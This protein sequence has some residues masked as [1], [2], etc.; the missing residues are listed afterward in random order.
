MIHYLLKSVKNEKSHVPFKFGDGRVINS[1]QTITFPAKIG[2]RFCN[3]KT[4]VVECKIPLLLSK[5]SLAKT[6]AVIDIGKD[7]VMIFSQKVNIKTTS[8]GHYCVNIMRKNKENVIL[9]VDSNIKIK[10]KRN[11]LLK[12]RKQ[13]GHASQEKL[14]N[15][16]KRASMVN[17]ET[18]YLLKDIYK[19]C[20]IC[21]KYTRPK[22]KPIVGFNLTNNFNQVIVLDLHEL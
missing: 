1:Y 17:Q 12:V 14:S 13:L 6:R 8:T 4:E 18:K 11:V 16:S 7:C 5:E 9:I 22:M 10:Y 3:T 20:A 2:N 21:H 19:K 15:L